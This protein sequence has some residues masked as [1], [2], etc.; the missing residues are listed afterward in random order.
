L[1]IEH[2]EASNNSIV[3]SRSL[4]NRSARRGDLFCHWTAQS[5]RASEAC[6]LHDRADGGH[7]VS[8]SWPRRVMRASTRCS[9]ASGSG[10]GWPLRW[11]WD[12]SGRKDSNLHPVART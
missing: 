12:W 10:G 5:G 9:T 2:L 8:R 1:V 3:A 4:E 6:E 11:H 7:V